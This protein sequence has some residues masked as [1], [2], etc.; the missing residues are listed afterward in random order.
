[1]KRFNNILCVV[2]PGAGHKPALER[3]ATL[4][5][6]NQ[7]NLTIIDVVERVT[8]GMRMPGDNPVFVDL[9]AAIV[10]ARKQELDSLIEPYRQ[11]INIQARVLIGTP[12]LEII[13]EILRNGCDLDKKR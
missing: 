10:N 11:R 1:M 7:A 8:V 12:F 6:N 4:T 2:T 13:R 5:E 9:Q 3:A